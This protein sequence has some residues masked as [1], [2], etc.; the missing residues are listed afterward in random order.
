MHIPEKGMG[1]EAVLRA[2]EAYKQDDLPWRSGKVMAYVY[3]PGEEALDVARQAFMMYMSESALDPTTF[4]SVMRLER[5]VVRMIIDLLRGDEQVVGNMTSGGTESILLAMKTA[6]DWMRIKR[7]EIKQPEMILPRTA[8]PAFHKACA[9]FDIKPVIIPFDRETFRADVGAMRAAIN[10]NTIVIV[11]S[12]PGYAQGVID[13]IPEIAALAQ[14]HALWCHVDGCVGGI[15][16]SFMRRL[17]YQLPDFDFTLPGVTSMSADMHKYGYAPKNASVVMYR[18]KELRRRQIFSCIQTTTYALINPTIMSS[19]SGAPL[20]GSWATLCHLGQDGY[21]RIVREVEDATQKLVDGVN[22][23][24]GLRVLGKPDMCLFSFAS[25]TISVFQIA[26]E[27]KKRGWYVQPQFS[28]ELSPA[29]LHITMN[30]SSLP[31]VDEFLAVLRDSVEAA[32]SNPPPFDAE[33]VRA[34][35]DQMLV[36]HPDNA[37]DMILAMAGISGS[38]LPDSMLLINMV[39]DCLPDP[40]AE[41][42]LAGYM[43]ELYS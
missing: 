38:Q 40:V 21:Q 42:L 8:H 20:A 12:A 37:A 16:L 41:D 31:C 32:R 15:H 11:G 35:I 24:D 26:E 7:P 3:D 6:R 14:E 10:A 43:N 34:Q 17:G 13:P 28:T 1:K 29:N 36:D 25:D 2:L 30:H 33:M 39:L 5:E 23:I 27:M 4:P 22:A 9:Y 18:N 19:K